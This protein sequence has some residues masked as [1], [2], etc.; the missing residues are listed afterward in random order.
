MIV[1]LLDTDGVPEVF[2]L[3]SVVSPVSD[4]SPVD[5]DAVVL[6]S[7]AEVETTGTEVVTLVADALNE[8]LVDGRQR[9]AFTPRMF[10]AA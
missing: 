9:P 1:S 6:L 7:E 4:V 5:A 8:V 3:A 10:A 2:V